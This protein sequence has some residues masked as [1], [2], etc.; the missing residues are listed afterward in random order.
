V[1]EKE[2]EGLSQETYKSVKRNLQ[3]RIETDKEG[4]TKET[5]K[6]DLQNT[7]VTD[8]EGQR[9]KRKQILKSTLYV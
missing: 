9:R 1:D 7:T 3:T 4:L 5:Y 6:P 2:N 8:K